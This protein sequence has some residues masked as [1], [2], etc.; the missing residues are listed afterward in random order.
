MP[1][2]TRGSQR[3]GETMSK[4]LIA[5]SCF[6][7]LCLVVCFVSPYAEGAPLNTRLCIPYEKMRDDLFKKYMEKPHG[8]GIAGNGELTEL[9]VSPDGKTWTIIQINPMTGLS[10]PRAFGSHWIKI[11]PNAEV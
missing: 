10:C 9:Y 8:H 3:L 6:L 1:L 2:F 7:L 11:D 5:I 4:F